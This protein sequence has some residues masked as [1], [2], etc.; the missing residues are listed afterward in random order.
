MGR[1]IFGRISGDGWGGGKKMEI[2]FL[3]KMN[4]V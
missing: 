3:R 1:D 4:V 2:G